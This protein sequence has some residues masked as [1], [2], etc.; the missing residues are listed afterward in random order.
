MP[1]LSESA[2]SLYKTRTAGLV[3]PVLGVCS[4]LFYAAYFSGWADPA[5]LGVGVAVLGALINGV[6]TAKNHRMHLFGRW[7]NTRDDGVDLSRWIFNLLMLDPTIVILIRPDPAAHFCTWMIL[8]LGAISDTLERRYRLTVGILGIV[9]FSGT[10]LWL[11]RG[12]FSPLQYAY[13]ISGMTALVIVAQRSY[14]YWAEALLELEQASQR[15][16]KSAEAISSMRIQATL[17]QQSRAIAHEI[18]NVVGLMN[19]S[20]TSTIA[21]KDQIMQRSMQRL[22]KICEAIG[23]TSKDEVAKK[24]VKVGDLLEDVKLL[25]SPFVAFSGV[26]FEISREKTVDSIQ[27][28]EM[29]GSTYLILH[30]LVKNSI[31][32]FDRSLDQIRKITLNVSTVST[33]DGNLS[34]RFS[35]GDNASGMDRE[36]LRLLLTGSLRTSKESGQGLGSKFVSSQCLENGFSYGGDSTKGQGTEIWVMAPITNDT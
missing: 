6:L 25:L 4:L 21:T 36:S 23:R 35:V 22:L 1:S 20:M 16:V 34:V 2:I 19:L 13:F 33:Q 14:A 3:L 15:E 31:E 7:L 18:K 27:I 9:S 5:A 10:F 11:H 17:G 30:N 26:S 32:A 8:L 24:T 29:E 28:T 12:T